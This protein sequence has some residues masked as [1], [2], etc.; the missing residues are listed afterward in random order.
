MIPDSRDYPLLVVFFFRNCEQAESRQLGLEVL[1]CAIY[2]LK[3]EKEIKKEI[4]LLYV[5]QMF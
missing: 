5:K 4:V 1:K 2:A 3:H